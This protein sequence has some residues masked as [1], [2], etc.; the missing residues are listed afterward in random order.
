VQIYNEKVPYPNPL[1]PIRIFKHRRYRE[2]YVDWHYHKETEILVILE[3]MLDVY[4]E[5]EFHPLKAGD[6]LLIGSSQL[7]R[8]RSHAGVRLK[9][10][11]FQADLG[12]Y[13][14]PSTMPYLKRLLGMN[15]PLSRLNYIFRE[16][17]DAR[18]RVIRCVEDIYAEARSREEGAELAVSIRI[19]EIML[20]LLRSDTRQVLPRQEPHEISRLK[21][22]LDY[23]EKNLTGKIQVEEASRIVNMSY[24]HFV[25]SFK[26][27]VGMSFVDYLNFQKI[28]LAERLLLTRDVSIARVGEEIGMPNMAHFYKVFRKFN[29]CSPK[30]YREKMREWGR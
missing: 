19:R 8:D 29:H 16:N 11:V 3:G 17:N 27:A 15:V 6:V 14:E 2:W 22:A 23:M 1:M 30:E 4:I 18:A 26:K 10:M 12:Q 9:Y 13:F 21:P 24:Y 20:T 5:D 25:K 7:H 28:K